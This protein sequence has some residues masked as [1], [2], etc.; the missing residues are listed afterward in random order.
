MNKKE[1]HVLK[2][3]ASK[4]GQSE[5]LGRTLEPATH[6]QSGSLASQKKPA[7]WFSHGVLI[8]NE[9]FYSNPKHLN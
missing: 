8:L 2:W 5:L 1:V 6:G 7:I 3:R 9:A 4:R